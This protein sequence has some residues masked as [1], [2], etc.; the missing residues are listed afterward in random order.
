MTDRRRDLESCVRG[1]ADALAVHNHEL[2]DRWADVAF[3]IW[4]HA[5]EEQL[6]EQLATGERA[7]DDASTRATPDEQPRRPTEA[8]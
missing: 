4:P 1:W 5:V 6:E 3:R 2:A 7:R 8:G